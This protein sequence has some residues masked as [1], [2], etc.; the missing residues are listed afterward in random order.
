MCVC[1]RERERERERERDQD[2]PLLQEFIKS[3]V[4]PILLISYEMFM[5][6]HD[7]LRKMT[8]DLMICDE[9]HRLKNTAIKTTSVSIY[10]CTCMH[11]YMYCSLSKV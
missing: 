11:Q 9:G 10:T 1:G 3:P 6:S 8:F 4:Y 2:P 5:R 7:L